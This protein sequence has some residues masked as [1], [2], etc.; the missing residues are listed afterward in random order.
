MKRSLR[1]F[2]WETLIEINQKSKKGYT[3]L[4]NEICSNV[5][6]FQ[7]VDED[8]FLIHIFCFFWECQLDSVLLK[9]KYSCYLY[10]M[11]FF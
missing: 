11:H 1:D 2:Y 10:L 4:L 3:V 8:I 9:E 5:F 7:N 6:C